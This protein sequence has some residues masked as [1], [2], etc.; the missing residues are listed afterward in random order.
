MGLGWIRDLKDTDPMHVES[1][2]EN[3]KYVLRP[4]ARKRNIVQIS[5]ENRQEPQEIRDPRGIHVNLTG[6]C[7]FFLR[8]CKE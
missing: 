1:G 7:N 3:P 4:R 8:K 2:C 5:P 6:L